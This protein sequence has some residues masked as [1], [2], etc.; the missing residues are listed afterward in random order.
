[1]IHASDLLHGEDPAHRQRSR[2]PHGRPGVDTT[3][4][5]RGP[6]MRTGGSDPAYSS[7][8]T[9]QQLART[10][11]WVEPGKRHRRAWLAMH[12][13]GGPVWD[14]CDGRPDTGMGRCRQRLR[15]HQR[16]LLRHD[17]RRGRGEDEDAGWKLISTS[18]KPLGPSVTPPGPLVVWTKTVSGDVVAQ[19]SLEVGSRGPNTPSFWELDASAAPAGTR[20]S[21]C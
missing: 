18:T 14:S 16:R 3:L 5:R 20:A 17:C 6:R 2:C 10:A 11:S 7:P 15:V 21:G 8:L 19:A 4:V 12:S 9:H 13:A 1:V